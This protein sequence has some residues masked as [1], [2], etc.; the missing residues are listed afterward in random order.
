[1]ADGTIEESSRNRGKVAIE[2]SY[3]DGELLNKLAKVLPCKCHIRERVRDTNFKKDYKSVSLIIYDYDF[4]KF[5]KYYIP[6]GKK[7]NKVLIPENLPKTDFLRGFIDGDGSIGITATGVPFVSIITS[8][9]EF[10]NNYLDFLNE[11]L[12]IKKIVNLNKRDGVYNITV[13]RE[14]AQNLIQLLYNDS[15]LFMER[16]YSK[17]MECLEWKR[18]KGSTRIIRRAW[19]KEEDNFIL[20]HSLQESVEHL[21]RSKQSIKSRLFRLQKR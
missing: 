9:K 18:P 6:V 15:S 16:K 17:A 3:K 12:G 7:S 4:R 2:L 1:M 19:D 20:S 21:K 8:S 10:V 14:D 13:T 11:A 5:L